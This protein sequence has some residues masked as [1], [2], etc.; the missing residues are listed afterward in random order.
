[1]YMFV[2]GV[3][4][5]SGL[6]LAYQ[7]LLP[8]YHVMRAYRAY[9][10]EVRAKRQPVTPWRPATPPRPGDQHREDSW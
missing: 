7:Q 5:G 4:F 8:W 10:T 2:L 3:L 9:N 6:V 1:M